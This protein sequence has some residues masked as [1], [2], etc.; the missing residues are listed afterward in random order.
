MGSPAWPA[1]NAGIRRGETVV[2]RQGA[3]E[4]EKLSRPRGAGRYSSAFATQ[5]QHFGWSELLSD[6]FQ[7]SGWYFL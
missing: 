1:E 4:F 3:T 5:H 6:L 2:E 7:L